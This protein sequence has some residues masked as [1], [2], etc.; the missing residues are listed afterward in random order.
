MTKGIRRQGRE[1][2]LKIIYSLQDQ[3]EPV[4]AILADFWQNF[5]FQNDILGEPIEV[6][7]GPLPFEVRRF[8]E[9]LILG[10]AENLE[11]I[12]QVIEEHSTNWA[13]DRM[14]RVDLS[15]LRMATYELLFQPETPTSVIINEAIE[16]G[17]R[18]GTKETPA[19]VNGILD[20]ISR[21]YRP[22]P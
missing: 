5:R 3:E 19:F 22:A 9:E 8:A 10:V 17:K 15:L 1:F 2:A 14:A 16:I 4:E 20:K 7:E 11:K 21:V 6:A 12:D 18:F 13:L